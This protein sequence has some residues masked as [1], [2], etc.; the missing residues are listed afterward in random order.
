MMMV[1]ALRGRPRLTISLT[2]TVAVFLAGYGFERTSTRLLTA[3]N[4]G[5]I[6]FR[7]E[8]DHDGALD[9]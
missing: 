8:L 4:A 3:W 5:V 1:D 2:L 7:A 6:L 9:A